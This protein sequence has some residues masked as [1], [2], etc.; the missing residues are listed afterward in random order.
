MCLGIYKCIHARVMRDLPTF[1]CCNSK[2]RMCNK[3]VFYV[4]I[5]ECIL[6][7][8]KAMPVKK[9]DNERAESTKQIN[10][11]RQH[12]CVYVCTCPFHY[13]S[14]WAPTDLIEHTNKQ[15]IL[16]RRCTSCTPC[17]RKTKKNI[18][19][20]NQIHQKSACRAFFFIWQRLNVECLYE[21]HKGK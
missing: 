14:A 9:K 19:A 16:H 8:K 3:S 15:R 1:R 7:I 2:W 11:L 17:F 6:I 21:H 10:N 13:S 18:P 20:K 5:Y 12:L 4:F